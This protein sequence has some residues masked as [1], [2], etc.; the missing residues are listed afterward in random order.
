MIRI[1]II[2]QSLYWIQGVAGANDVLQPDILWAQFGQS[3]TINCSHTKGSVYRE[4]YWFRQYQGESME[5]IVYTTS[6]GTQDFGKSDQKKFSAI[7]TVPENGSFTVKDVDYNDNAVYFCAVRD[8]GTQPA[9]FGQGTKLTVLDPDM[10]LQAPTVTVLNVSE[11]EVCTKENVTLVCVAKGFYPDHVKVYWT[12]DEVN[13]TIDV[14]T[15]EAAV[16]G[17]DKYYTIS[18]R[19]NIDYKT[20]WTRGKTFTC[21]VNFFNGT[22]INYKDSITGPKLTIDEDNYETYVR[23]VKTTM[24]RY[25]MFVAKSIAYGIFIM[26]IVRRQGFMSK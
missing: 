16:Q 21:I 7:K 17:S 26:Y 19:L 15:D 12:V 23:S 20:E 4:M 24:L 11:K 9:Y 8:R 1:I 18:S 14:S 2:F 5:L 10:K 6:F 22:G 3:V 25:G 13:R